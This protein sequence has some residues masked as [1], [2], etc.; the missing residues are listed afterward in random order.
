MRVRGYTLRD[1]VAHRYVKMILEVFS[2]AR[3]VHDA[4]NANFLK[5]LLRAYTREHQQP[6]RV[7]G[8]A[9]ENDL[10]AYAYSNNLAAYSFCTA[11]EASLACLRVLLVIISRCIRI[12]IIIGF[13]VIIKSRLE[14]KFYANGTFG[15]GVYDNAT[16]WRTKPYAECTGR[17]LRG[18]GELPMLRIGSHHLKIRCG[19]TALSIS[20][21]DVVYINAKSSLSKVRVCWQTKAIGSFDKGHSHGVRRTLG[22]VQI[23]RERRHNHGAIFSVNLGVPWVGLCTL[24]EGQDSCV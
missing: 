7:N 18:G 1:A 20:C 8:T 22:K 3:A 11:N 17:F 9:A 2:D 15:L 6:R 4:I 12:N 5:I 24:E 10:L 23:M 19:V 16:Y 14:F 13:V 21:I